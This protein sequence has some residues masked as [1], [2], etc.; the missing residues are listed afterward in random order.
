MIIEVNPVHHT[1][2]F[3]EGSMASKKS[4]NFKA[5]DKILSTTNGIV[6]VE[7][8]EGNEEENTQSIVKNIVEKLDSSQKSGFKAFNF[9]FISREKIKFNSKNDYPIE[10]VKKLADRILEFGLMHNLE[11]LYDEDSDTYTLESGE[12]RTRAIDYLIDKFQ[13]TKNK[14]TEEYQFYLKNVQ[15][16]AVEGYPCNV[17]GNTS[18]NQASELEM[19]DSEIRLIIANEE[20]RT[21]DVSRSREKIMRLNE[22]LQQRNEI[23]HKK[24]NVNKEIAQT[25]GISDRQVMKYK[26]LSKLIPELQELFDK[27]GITINE[28]ANYAQLQ[29]EEQRQLLRLIESGQ[30]KKE[31][32][33]LY[34]KINTMNREMEAQKQEIEQ[35]KEDKVAA[36]KMVSKAQEEAKDIEEKIRKELADENRNNE[37]ILTLQLELQA[38]KEKIR[39]T[40]ETLQEKNHMQQEKIAAL[41]KNTAVTLPTD[42]NV[43]KAQLQ[44]D[45]KMKAVQNAI[46]ELKDVFAEYQYTFKKNPDIKKPKEYENKIIELLKWE[47]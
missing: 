10:S 27:N 39:K 38:A 9:K 26:S 31:V 19:L 1:K 6:E 17:K 14:N 37:E 5:A 15:Q 30:D 25:L 32:N 29:E 46:E 34:E 21:E 43:I 35:L 22:L 12:R 20:V 41:E 28:G 45:V 47:Q 3:R 18:Q 7:K 2:E 23:L 13:N 33:A 40:E 44:M 36:H 8:A 42:I 4:F 11:V 16:F 24:V